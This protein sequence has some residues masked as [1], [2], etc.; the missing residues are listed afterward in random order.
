[1]IVMID[2]FPPPSFRRLP[3]LPRRGGFSLLEILVAVGVLSLILVICLGL[4]NQFSVVISRSNELAGVY[5]E[6]NSALTLIAS[7][8]RQAVLDSRPVLVNAAGERVL[9]QKPDKQMLW[10]D[11]MLICGPEAELLPGKTGVY[12]HAVFFQA[13]MGD[14]TRGRSGQALNEIG[15][16]LDCND[17]NPP[18]FVSNP[19]N[20][21]RLMQ[22]RR[23]P[24]TTTVQQII[25]AARSGTGDRR[26]WYLSPVVGQTDVQPVANNILAL[27]I[28]PKVKEG[29]GPIN[30]QTNGR[31]WSTFSN[32]FFDSQASGSWQHRIPPMLEITLIVGS[33]ESLN[34][35]AS[36]NPQ[37]RFDFGQSTLF[38]SLT[39]ADEYQAQL[40]AFSQELDSKSIYH[41]VFT[42]TV[43]LETGGNPL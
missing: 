26:D 17:G 15:Y 31:G 40:N 38:S 3:G 7:H 29:T 20:R 8:L 6:G 1:M 35:Y 28:V 14:A 43:R 23:R 30:M 41:R 12:S 32:Y 42:T 33:K 9:E 11:L 25:R 19:G 22:Y 18:S 5:R 13:L 27:I 36:K 10:S 2:F 39:T 21:L 4:T 37:T 34:R 24:G 16:F